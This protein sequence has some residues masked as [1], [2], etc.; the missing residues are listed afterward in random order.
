MA[1]QTAWWRTRTI[2]TDDLAIGYL[3]LIL[4]EMWLL[5]AAGNLR[6]NQLYQYDVQSSFVRD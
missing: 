3:T 5:T 2:D 4:M 6:L 1:Q